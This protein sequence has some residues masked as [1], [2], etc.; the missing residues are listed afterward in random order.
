M[1]SVKMLL[2]MFVSTQAVA[3]MFSLARSGEG[4]AVKEPHGSPRSGNVVEA[5]GFHGEGE[6]KNFKWR[7]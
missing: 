1:P 7:F 3:K 4:K 6:R 2:Y 5:K